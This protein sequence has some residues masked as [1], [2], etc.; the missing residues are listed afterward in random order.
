M[1]RSWISDISILVLL[2]LLGVIAVVLLSG[3]LQRKPLTLAGAIMVEDTDARKQ[4]PIAGVKI[5]AVV[6]T[7][8]DSAISDSS[9][10]FRITLPKYVRRGEAL[11]FNFEAAGYKPLMVHDYAGDK[12]YVV[13]LTRASVPPS[14]QPNHPRVSIGNIVVRYSVKATAIV[15]VGSAVK[16][17]EVVNQ[18]NVPCNGKHPC[19]PDGKWKA[20]VGSATLDAGTGNEFRNVRASCIAGPCPFTEIN[21]GTQEQRGSTLKVSATDWSDT[22]TF[23]VEAEV[24]HP[25]ISNTNRESYPVIFGP[26][27]NFTLPA[28]AGGV[29]IQADVNGESIIFPLGPDLILSWAECNARTTENDSKVYR[30]ELK[31]G[32]RFK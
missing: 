30:C 3:V 18:G 17:F 22:A 13:R 1:A 26:A 24:V 9:G 29:S 27:L 2:S 31:P 10:S 7:V 23:L 28:S 19:S 16:A 12:L 5:S 4:L 32:F 15:N 6:G 14:L 21:A 8:N 11:T 20:A 25:M